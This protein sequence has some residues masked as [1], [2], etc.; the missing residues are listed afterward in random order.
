MTLCARVYLFMSFIY[1][2]PT[3]HQWQDRFP[4][5]GRPR[6]VHCGHLVRLWYMCDAKS[7]SLS[8]PGIT[9]MAVSFFFFFFLSVFLSF[10]L[11]YASPH[12]A[13]STPPRRATRTA[14]KQCPCL[15]FSAHWKVG[16]LLSNCFIHS[17]TTFLSYPFLQDFFS[18]YPGFALRA[19]VVRPPI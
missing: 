7:C 19:P 14:L 10:F 18:E 12:T 15:K 8:P 5:M 3:T 6:A 13:G 16:L 4:S 17:I 9:F 1:K 11:C 2:P